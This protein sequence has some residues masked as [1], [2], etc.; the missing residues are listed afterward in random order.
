M[1][2]KMELKLNKLNK[3]QKL[4]LLKNTALLKQLMRKD[5]KKLKKRT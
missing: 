5:Y 4:H 2:L 3:K 1:A